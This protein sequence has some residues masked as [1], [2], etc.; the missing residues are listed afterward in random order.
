MI[1]EPNQLS[2]Y[3]LMGGDEGVR[4]L[5]DRFYQ[6]MDESPEAWE[7]RKLHPDDLS[8]S[9]DKL[10]MFLSGWLGGPQLYVEKHGHPMLRRRHFPFP[11]AERERDQWLMCM[12]QALDEMEIDSIFRE[13]LKTSFFKVADHMRNREE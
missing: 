8:S 4:K 3:D 10:Y 11:I 9:V 7:I 12:N 13:Q 5:V 1:N 2:H 6:I